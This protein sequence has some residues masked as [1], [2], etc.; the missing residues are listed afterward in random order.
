MAK[1]TLDTVVNA[2]KLLENSKDNRDIIK[3]IELIN[4]SKPINIYKE[5]IDYIGN[6]RV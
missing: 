3:E 4:N 6:K 5:P 1:L 2:I